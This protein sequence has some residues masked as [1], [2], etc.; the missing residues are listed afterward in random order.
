MSVQGGRRN[1]RGR[2]A[3]QVMIPLIAAG[4][5]LALSACGSS[6]HTATNIGQPTDAGYCKTFKPLNDQVQQALGKLFG[7][8]ATSDDLRSAS[9]TLVAATDKAVTSNPPADIRADLEV[10]HQTFLQLQSQVAAVN[11]DVTKLAGPP[12]ALNDPKF[13]A[14][15]QNI[16]NYGSKY[17]GIQ[18][19][20]GPGGGP[21]SGGPPPASPG[22]NTIAIQNFQFSTLTAAPG[23]KITVQN[24]DPM[25]HSVTADD[26][27]FDTSVISAHQQGTFTAPAKPGTYTYHCLVH[28]DMHGTLVVTG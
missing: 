16:V 18:P 27:S 7:P 3:A 5:P 11:Y 12:P 10:A 15:R 21:G 8:G 14:A 20:E 6:T 25:P 13:N 26:K 24:S 17:C 1:S 22:P 28:P 23:A 2:I 9:A 19:Q 4:A